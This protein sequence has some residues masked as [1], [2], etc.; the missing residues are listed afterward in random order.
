[1]PSS[2]RKGAGTGGLQA[3]DRA[4][5]LLRILGEHPRGLSLTELADIAQLPPSTAHRL[6]GALREH[7]LVRE[8]RD[9]RNALG[10][11]TTVL[12]GAFLEALDLRAEARPIM[13]RLVQETGETCHLGVLAAPH[14]VYIE[15]VDS[16]QAVRMVSYVG[17]TN[18]AVSTALGL[19]ILAHSPA[20]VVDT[21]VAASAALPGLADRGE[22]VDADLDAIRDRGY[23]LDL[24]RN[25]AGICCIGAPV[26]DHTGRVI[27]AISVTAPAIRFDRDR[28]P[29]NGARV[30]GAADEITRIFGGGLMGTN[31]DPHAATDRARS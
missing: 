21:T 2:V 28:I 13:R 22:T 9:G 24:E 8:T 7:H 10:P 5:G 14:I 15:K 18:P 12:A 20:D 27:A 1:M 6:L 30:R 16:P 29:E 19:A 23:S 31:G 25:E 26:F 3:V 17:G 4:L 11:A